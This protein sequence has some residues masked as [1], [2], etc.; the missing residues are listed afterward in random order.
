MHWS[1]GSCACLGTAIT[2]GCGFHIASMT[3]PGQEAGQ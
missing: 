2:V 3:L 1:D